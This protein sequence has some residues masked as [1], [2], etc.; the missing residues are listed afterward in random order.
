MLEAELEGAYNLRDLGGIA[1][2]G[3]RPIRPARLW[4]SGELDGLSEAAAATLAGLG[5]RRIVD[6]RSAAERQGA[7]T[8]ARALES[9][10][11]WQTAAD[12]VLGDPAPIL[13]QCLVSPA[14]SSQTMHQ[15]YRRM[16]FEHRHAYRALLEFAAAGEPLLFHC[17][18]GKDRTGVAAALL[19]SLLGV[20]REA[21]RADFAASN[22]AIGQTTARFLA[23]PG[24]R[25]TQGIDPAVWHPM[26]L[27]DPAYIDSLFDE[28]AARHGHVQ[29][30]AREVL[31]LPADIGE[32]LQAVL[33]AW[34]HA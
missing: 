24:S 33:L 28:I 31:G 17:A 11:R 29:G 16:A 8:R 2:A 1:A 20:E 22:A 32:R 18:A 4:R 34:P 30:Y 3:G 25:L 21:I 6:F 5:L 7:P 26:M 23:K 12:E 27:A 13:R 9:L 14:Q 15:V 19:L 10:D